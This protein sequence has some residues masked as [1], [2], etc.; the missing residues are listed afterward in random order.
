M[1]AYDHPMGPEHIFLDRGVSGRRLD[2]AATD[3]LRDQLAWATGILPTVIPGTK[4]SS[5]SS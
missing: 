3:R 4:D 2:R 1:A 5:A